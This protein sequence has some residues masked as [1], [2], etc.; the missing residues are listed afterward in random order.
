MS[1]S[2]V[3]YLHSEGV[4]VLLIADPGRF[5][6]GNPGGSAEAAAA[7][8]E[9]QEL[10]APPG[11]AIFRDVETG[12][13]ITAAYIESWY[14]AFAQS[15]SGYV[16]GFY[17]NAYTGAF[18]GS[19]GAF[20]TAV[21]A[22]PSI[23]SGTVLWSSE[24]EPEYGDQTYYPTPQ[25]AP[26]WG[27]VE[28]PCAATTV[29]WQY[30]ERGGFPAG[31]GDPNVDVDLFST[32]A[33]YPALLW[34]SAS[35]PLLANGTL[36]SYQGSN[37]EIAGGAPLYVS[38][39]G[40][41]PEGQVPTLALT[42]A[43]WQA[44]NPVPADGTFITVGTAGPAY[45]QVYEIAGGAPLHLS[46]WSDVGPS[47]RP[48]NLW[49]DGWDLANVGS[50]LSHLSAAPAN[51]TLIT[52]GTPGAGSYGSVYEV[53]GGAPLHVESWSDLPNVTPHSLWVDGWAITNAG[54]DTS[55]VYSALTVVPAN[56]TFLTDGTPGSGWGELYEIVGG[57]PLYVSSWADI[58]N[59]TASSAIVDGWDITNAGNPLTHLNAVP[60]N[61]TFIT[62]GTPG[63]SYGQVYEIAGGAPLYVSS[64][65]DIPQVTPYTLWADGWDIANAGNPLTHLNAV[66][67][68]G[69]FITVGTS[70]A[71]Y[72]QIYEIAGGAPL[73]V[74]SWSDIP[75]VSPYTLW[76]DAWDISNAGDDTSS[77]YNALT[78]VPANGTFITVG[79]SGSAYG[80]V[81]EIAGG[82]PL[83]VSSW[84][85]MPGGYPGYTLLVDDW[86]LTNL[87]N[88]ADALNA[89]PSNGTYIT[90]GTPGSAYG[91]VYEIAG[92]APLHVESWGDL[93]GGYPG[94]TLWV[95][96]WD[97]AKISNPAA[98]LNAVPANGTYITESSSDPQVNGSVF[99]IAGGAPL[100][101]ESWSDIP[102]G[103]PGYTLWVDGWDITNAGNPLT[104]LNAVPSNGTFIT[105]R[106]S[107]RIVR[108]G[109][110]DRGR[111][112]AVRE[113]LDRHPTSDAV[114]AM[115]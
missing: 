26:A 24:L 73:F 94:Y 110:R 81:Y 42:A 31:S 48:Y 63:A 11:T 97:L 16:P 64:W 87:G 39:W 50:P 60:S 70:G 92:G 25:N 3:A 13:S 47:A 103:Y 43:Q 93:P 20:C 98:H 75:T 61:G 36:V 15:P 67:A 52:D 99:V 55:P 86:D 33:G 91:Q 21:G 95:D 37:Y 18:T 79:T 102:G 12:D 82:A 115:G 101:V 69:T 56:G 49:I 62:D 100:H 83:Y 46:S 40:D 4:S 74:D 5:G 106:N 59:A 96:G 29:A 6:S 111:G 38:S 8:Q 107:R 23:A 30:E 1:V 71:S 109:V 88:A 104:H 65:T 77:P 85:D 58:P 34:G 113:Q 112:A 105:D 41:L 53:V 114:H 68:N 17:E 76:V 19:S 89:V 10:G 84:S 22:I 45:G 51:G 57:A 14:Q 78:A 90:I 44:L 80:Q 28:P 66:P 27:P 72:G 35:S 9:A 108:A 2:E 7:I 54:A 32:A